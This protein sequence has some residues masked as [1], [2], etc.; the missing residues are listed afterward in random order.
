MRFAVRQ[1][2]QHAP[3]NILPRVSKNDFDEKNKKA[4]PFALQRASCWRPADG[5]ILPSITLNAK[6]FPPE[7]CAKVNA[8]VRFGAVCVI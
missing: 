2:A 8:K 1:S 4:P 5:S 7:T 3:R 6:P